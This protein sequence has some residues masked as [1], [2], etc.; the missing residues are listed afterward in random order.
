MI[1][2]AKPQGTAFER[3][4]PKDSQCG[5][6]GRERRGWGVTV[7]NTVLKGSQPLYVKNSD[8]VTVSAPSLKALGRKAIDSSQDFAV[9]WTLRGD[10]GI[11]PE[12]SPSCGGGMAEWREAS[13]I[14]GSPNLSAAF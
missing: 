2:N 10:G 14:A 6:S 3:F 12:E 9:N 7:T 13:F 5:S 8:N 4:P 1:T 11:N